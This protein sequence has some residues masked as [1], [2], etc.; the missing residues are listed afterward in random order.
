M[1]TWRRSIGLPVLWAVWLATR[2]WLYL[3]ATAPGGDGDVGIYQRWYACCLAHGRFPLADPMWQYPPGAALVLWLP[4]RP[5]GGYVNSFVFLAIG[6]D[7][8]IILMLCGRARRGGSLAGAWYWVGGV[9]LLGAV[10][11]VRF[12]VVPVALSVAALCVTGRGVVRG[13]LAGAGAA[14]KVWPVTLLAGMAPGQGR[15]ALAAAA[16]VLAAVCVLFASQTAS[17][18]AHQNARGVEIESVA[19]TPFMIGR[20]AG[21][22][23]TVVFRFGAWQLSGAH[24][25]LAQDGSRLGLVLAAA[26]VLGWRLLIASGRARWRPEFSAD[27][28]L[29]A[30]LLFLVASPVLSAQYLLWVTGLAAACLATG[31]TT[32][33]PAAL[34]VLAAAGL[35][36][37]VFP[38]GWPSLVHGSG[39]VTAVLAARNLLLVAAAVLSCRRIIRATSPRHEE[40]VR[41]PG[42]ATATVSAPGRAAPS[43]RHAGQTWTA[44]NGDNDGH[45]TPP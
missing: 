32:Q 37:L 4:G 42:S 43:A 5:P 40:P 33:R 22:H 20:H 15:R 34:A 16:A 25:A 7:L 21:W 1:L 29:A 3:L 27:A 23:G 45:Q 44:D 28:P 41:Q 11:I 24:V 38:I 10:T 17:F 12:D 18:L 39:L 8:A 9:P 6:C 36:Q 2:T 13:A 31:R 26:A 14:V 30:T 19:A 35:T